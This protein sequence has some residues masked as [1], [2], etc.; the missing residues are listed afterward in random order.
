MGEPTGMRPLGELIAF[1][2]AL[3]MMRANVRAVEGSERVEIAAAVG[4]V[5]AE[6]VRAT[7]DSPAVDRSRMDGFAVASS[8]LAG[9]SGFKTKLLSVA[10][11]T[12]A[13]GA[14][15]A[16]LQPG[17]CV[18]VA[19]GAS[20]PPGADTVVPV[21]DARPTGGPIVEFKTAVKPGAH[22]SRR[23]SDYRA[24]DVLLSAGSLVTP[25]RIAAAASANIAH[26][27]VRR[28]PRVLIVPTGDEVVPLGAPLAEGHIRESNSHALAAFIA[29][30]GGTPECHAI[31]A[32]RLEDVVQALRTAGGYDA[33]VFTGGTSAGVKDFLAPALKQVGTVAFHGVKLRP[34]KPVV[35]G[36]AF[37]K[38]ILG[39]PGNPTSCMV[40]AYL[41]LDRMLAHLLGTVPPSLASV[42]AKLAAD[43]SS[44][45]A[46]SPV[47]FL[48]L[49]LVR[50][51]G[52]SAHPV[53]KDS[54]SVMGAAQGDGFF[55]VGPGRPAPNLGD[56]VSV[57]LLR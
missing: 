6:E 57:V 44:Y 53:L 42:K 50:L 21:E 29:S 33:A 26:L 25:S 2:R 41:F 43:V 56:D 13:G 32:D 31:V 20:L 22:V 34:G 45:T 55:V 54:M 39:L 10:G 12:S 3:E 46:A 30:R 52:S 49:V 14:A 36:E 16:P 1:D 4:R 38:P 47:D 7:E 8:D 9:L 28:R 15:A 19:T 24:D 17:T 27:K 51:D 23:G 37:G 35:L 11:R 40:D 18:E 5:L 48:T